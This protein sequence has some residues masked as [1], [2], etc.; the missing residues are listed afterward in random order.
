MDRT[1]RDW[2]MTSLT[3]MSC[4][5]ASDTQNS[6][7]FI[8]EN[9]KVLSANRQAEGGQNQESADPQQEG[10]QTNQENQPQTVT[11]L[12]PHK[13]ALRVRLA[14]MTGKLSMVL[15]G[16]EDP[17]KTNGGFPSLER[18]DLFHMNLPQAAPEQRQVTS[19]KV[20]GKDGSSTELLFDNSGR[21]I[22]E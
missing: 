12:L 4:N 19:V 7:I 22:N 13:D 3:Q 11:L 2:R 8:A 10:Q 16:T 14:A 9:V 15:R 17:G 5:I 18:S 21:R 20:K 1:T 6:I